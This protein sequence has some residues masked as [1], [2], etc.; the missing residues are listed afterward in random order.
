MTRAGLTSSRVVAAGA[1]LAD[2]VGFSSLTM[3][4]LAERVGVRTPSLYRHIAHQEDLNRRIAVLAVNEA[5]DAMNGAIRGMS[6]REALTRGMH[7]FRDYV[8]AHPGRYAATIGV[9]ALAP[10]DAMALARDRF[11]ASLATIIGAYDVAPED[12]MHAM[13]ALR[14]IL[15]GFGSLQAAHGF[16]H[17]TDVD[18]SFAWLIDLTDRGLR[19]SD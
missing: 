4:L 18:E 11:E 7:A 17:A 19:R 13:R 5:A 3:A 6:G 1:A 14:S 10:G 12:M 8:L 9:E 2:E 16:Q 15:H